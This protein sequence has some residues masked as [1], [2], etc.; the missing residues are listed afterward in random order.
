MQA[1][2]GDVRLRRCRLRQQ[3]QQQQRAC[4]GTGSATGLHVTDTT[5][6]GAHRP[7][8][9]PRRACSLVVDT[10]EMRVRVRTGGRRFFV[11]FFVRSFIFLAWG[12]AVLI[13][14]PTQSAVHRPHRRQRLLGGGSVTPAVFLH[15]SASRSAAAAV[16]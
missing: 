3:Q 15:T 13:T 6:D 5:P 16:V 14:G 10:A 12:T 8:E 9:P 7:G 1:G 11:Y 2:D 4:G